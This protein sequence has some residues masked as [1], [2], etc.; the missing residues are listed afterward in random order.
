MTERS[1][2]HRKL[3]SFS[4]HLLDAFRFVLVSPTLSA[5]IG[6]AVRALS[7]MAF[8]ALTVVAPRDASFRV[9]AG[10]LPLSPVS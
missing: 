3:D 7:T 5:N 9:Q 10:A 2:T 8:P 6:S 1:E 4:Q